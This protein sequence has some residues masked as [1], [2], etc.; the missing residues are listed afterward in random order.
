MV[1]ELKIKLQC[2][3]CGR[4][5]VLYSI[6]VR[7]KDR[8]A[9]V[10]PMRKM[11]THA[12]YSKVCRL[13]PLCTVPGLE[14][15]YICFLHRVSFN[16]DSLLIDWHFVFSQCK[17]NLCCIAQ[18]FTLWGQMFLQVQSVLLRQ[19]PQTTN[20]VSWSYLKVVIDQITFPHRNEWKCH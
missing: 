15:G 6:L 17:V 4:K 16:H 1:V 3:L 5:F 2:S 19:T 7:G 20:K 18:W 13:I 11:F 14:L 8:L 10:H 12:S 9:F